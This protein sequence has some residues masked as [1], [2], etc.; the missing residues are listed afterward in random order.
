MSKA[1]LNTGQEL[2]RLQA[3]LQ[4]LR[5]AIARLQDRSLDSVDSLLSV[6]QAELDRVMKQRGER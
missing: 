3:Q 5:A 4:R 6:V 1:R 2:E